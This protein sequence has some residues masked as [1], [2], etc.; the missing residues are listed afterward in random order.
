M[1]KYD[2]IIVG[3]GP[4]GIY[5]AYELMSKD[6]NLKVLLVD[7]G[8]DIYH[9]TCPVLE[10]KIK[11]C[12]QD[13][14]GNSGCYPSCS[15]TS[16]FGGCGAFSDGKFNI[17]NEFGGWMDEYLDKKEVIDLIKYVDSINLKHGAPDVLTNP[18]TKEVLEIEKKGYAVGLKLLRSQV[19]HL[20]TEVNLALLKSI[21]EELKANGVEMKFS[22]EITDIIEE[23]GEIKGVIDFKNNQYD[24]NYV[25]LNVGRPGSKWLSSMLKKHKVKVT[26]NRVDIGVRVETNDVIMDEINKNLYEGKFVYATSV[27]T[28]VRTFCSNPSGHVVIE[29]NNG[30]IT[31]NGHA[32]NSS[33]LGSKNTNFALLVS[34]TFTEPFKDSNEYAQDISALANKLSGGT[35]IVQRFGDIK[36]GR[37]STEKRIAEGFVEPTLK[38][39]VPGDLALILPYKTLQSIIEMIEAL[40]HVTPG[41][42]NDHT[43]LYGVEAKFYSDKVECGNNFE[44]KIINLYVGGDGAGITRGLAQAGA[45][46]VFVARD[47]LAK[48]GL[49]ND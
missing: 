18:N 23:N 9:R 16:G 27:G 5:C 38:E 19:R 41:I 2:V 4:C 25:I 8:K 12:P 3:A 35:V 30:I 26:N 34:H 29:N 47:I 49:K 22:T 1:A 42:A 44:T 39:A 43:L 32:Y 20:G 11:Q 13:I 33:E 10:G 6:K 14:Y 36:K 24:A 15:M 46:G 48:E 7:K 37:R 17:T 21:Y 40:D 28:T 31:A 45:N